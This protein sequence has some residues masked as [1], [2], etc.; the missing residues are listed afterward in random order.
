MGREK[1]DAVLVQSVTSAADQRRQSCREHTNKRGGAG[2]P[3]CRVRWAVAALELWET[4]DRPNGELQ[5]RHT[6]VPVYQIYPHRRL[7]TFQTFEGSGSLTGLRS[8]PEATDGPKATAPP[9]RANTG[10]NGRATSASSDICRHQMRFPACSAALDALM[11]RRQAPH[12][13]DLLFL[14]G[15]R[16]RIISGGQRE[17]VHEVPL[18]IGTGLEAFG[19]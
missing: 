1:G 6:L 2:R 7:Q 10:P 8:H 16:I 3:A 9:G 11:G 17:P 13:S 18:S 15:Y 4:G 5:R 19:K 12:R 14:E